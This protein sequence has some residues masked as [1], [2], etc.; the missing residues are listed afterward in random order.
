MKLGNRRFES[1]K[2]SQLFIGVH[3]EPLAIVA[4][5][6]NNLDRSPIGINR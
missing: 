5:C 4:V 1:K 2:R 6:V 3:N